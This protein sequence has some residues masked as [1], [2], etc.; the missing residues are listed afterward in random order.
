[1]SGLLVES[2]AVRLP[3]PDAPVACGF[4][5]GR[6]NDMLGQEAA[7]R[8]AHQQVLRTLDTEAARHES[9]LGA[10]S[11]SAT[12]LRR[13]ASGYERSKPGRGTRNIGAGHHG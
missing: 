3:L 8:M 13:A 5:L 2:C 7:A 1:M 9:I 11:T 12:S 4:K 6:A 10:S